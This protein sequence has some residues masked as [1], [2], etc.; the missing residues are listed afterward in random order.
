MACEGR[1]NGG[2]TGLTDPSAST[3]GSI[4]TSQTP[5]DGLP[6]DVVAL[7]Q[8]SCLSCHGN[9]STLVSLTSRDALLAKAAS[10]PT[11]TVAEVML[12]RLNDGTMP[13]MGSPSPTAAEVSALSAWKER[14]G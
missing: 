3:N 11:K 14:T 13:P 8:S 6:C 1:M 12:A 10:D 5:V 9:S 2:A 4:A 7:L